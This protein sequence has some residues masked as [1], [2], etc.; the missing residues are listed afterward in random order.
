M[1]KKTLKCLFDNVFWYLI[2]LLPLILL[3]VYWCKTGAISVVGAMNDAGLGI[4][5][6]NPV[7]TSLNGIFGADG[8]V[9]FFAS[10]DIIAYGSYF[11]CVFIFHLAVDF[12]LFIPRL[13]HKWMN[14]LGGDGNE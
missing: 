12:L 8:V 14:F 2:Y 4:I 7:Y 5:T 3:V 1:R 10:P 6:T 11:V 13:C 9:P